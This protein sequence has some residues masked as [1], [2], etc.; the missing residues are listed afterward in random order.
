MQI[1]TIMAEEEDDGLAMAVPQFSN[2]VPILPTGA[3]LFPTVQPPTNVTPFLDPYSEDITDIDYLRA[4][5]TCIVFL[6]KPGSGRSTLAKRLAKEWN[7]CYIHPKSLIE[8]RL[9]CIRIR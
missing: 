3:P 2:D 9:H 1:Q 4:K 5:P 8:V 6:G 7:F